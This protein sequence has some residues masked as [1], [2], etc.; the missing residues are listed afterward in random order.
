MNDLTLSLNQNVLKLS[1]LDKDGLKTYQ[2]E[3]SPDVINDSKITDEKMFETVLKDSVKQLTD[4]SLKKTN[5]RILLEPDDLT[6]MFITVNKRDG[7][8]EAQINKEIIE[9]VGETQLEYMY[10]SYVKIAPFAY[11]FIGI[12]KDAFDKFLGIA[13]SL[14]AN[15]CGIYSWVSLLPKFVNRNDPCIFIAKDHEKQMV[16]L[17]ELN[18]IYFTGQYEVDRTPQELSE[19]VEQLSFYKRPTP[20]TKIYT[21][22]YDSFSIDPRYDVSELVIENEINPLSSKP[23]NKGFEQHLILLNLLSKTSDFDENQVNLLNLILTPVVEK[24]NISLVVVGSSLIVTAIILGGLVFYGV[25]K[26]DTKSTPATNELAKVPTTTETPAVLAETSQTTQSSPAS[27]Q[28][29]VSTLNK[30]DISIR[31]ENGSGVTG[32]AAKSRDLLVGKGFNAGEIATATINRDT[33]LLKIKTSKVAYKDLFIDAFK[34]VY[35][36]LVE[37]GLDEKLPYDILVVIGAKTP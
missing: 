3:I 12:K 34:G 31:I 18:G 24:K 14:G 25:N 28:T 37:N 1:Y 5:L 2:Q 29:P 27:T 7:E 22:N 33:T 26:F 36:V 32:A 13:T 11:Q 21:L 30:K 23:E 6:M 8:V 19:L 16:A 4:V 15:L 10:Y 20:I 17:S 35:T 9:R